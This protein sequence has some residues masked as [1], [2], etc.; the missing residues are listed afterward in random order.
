MNA[1][2]KNDTSEGKPSVVISR[3]IVGFA[4][5]RRGDAL[6]DIA[7]TFA[8]A[9]NANL[10]GVY[11]REEALRDLAELPFT[12]AMDPGLRGQR[13][14][15]AQIIETAWL[16]EEAL[17]RRA[18][19]QRAGVDRIEWSFETASGSIE[20]YLR[21]AVTRSDLVALA[22]ET[23]GPVTV[24]FMEGLPE[25]A[26]AAHAVLLVGSRQGKLK[27]GPILAIDEGG[28]SGG[29]IVRL[30]A[31]IASATSRPL[32]VVSSTG[33]ADVGSILGVSNLPRLKLHRLDD[34][35]GMAF[36]H[37]LYDMKPSLIVADREASALGGDAN[38][39][40]LIHRL[41]IPIL[42]VDSQR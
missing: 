31:Q 17:Y 11:I 22:A 12:T 15:S 39:R 26:R 23:T 16:R 8:R 40:A 7:A 1:K 20:S 2:K 19:S 32:E 13:P 38:I 36:Q 29:E 30:S 25:L 27:S 4:G 5:T 35:S 18:I 28:A 14:L 6:V 10:K 37:M 3:V 9:L 42:F 33:T 41:G 21:E 24:P 34:T